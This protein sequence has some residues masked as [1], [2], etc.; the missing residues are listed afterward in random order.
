MPL[1][2]SNII[3]LGTFTIANGAAASNV[4]SADVYTGFSALMIFAPATL[5]NTIVIQTGNAP[6]DAGPTFETVQSPPGTDVTIPQGKA[7]VITAFP[8]PCIR[9]ATQAGANEGQQDVF[10]LWAQR[11]IVASR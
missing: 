5:T 11:Q 1:E 10:Q 7:V 2:T 4:I 8:F 3:Q 9:V 6:F